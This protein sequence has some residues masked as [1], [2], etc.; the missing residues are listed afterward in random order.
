MTAMNKLIEF[1]MPFEMAIR[2]NYAATIEDMT[3][4]DGTRD[5]YEWGVFCDQDLLY[6]L[7]YAVC[8]G[9]EKAHDSKFGEADGH[10]VFTDWLNA[11]FSVECAVLEFDGTV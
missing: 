2:K 3:C 5:D 9:L 11:L 4:S 8:P 6:Y 10:N 7:A 1:A